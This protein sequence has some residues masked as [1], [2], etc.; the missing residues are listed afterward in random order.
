VL[1]GWLAPP[2]FDCTTVPLIKRMQIASALAR[3]DKIFRRIFGRILI[4]VR[5]MQRDI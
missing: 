4:P 1:T 5:N 2:F 3:I